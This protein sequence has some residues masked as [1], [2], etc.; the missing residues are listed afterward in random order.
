MAL[1]KQKIKE[2]VLK[3][4]KNEKDTGTPEVQI[5]LLTERIKILTKHFE[6]HKKDVLTRRNFLKLINR[7]RKLLRYLKSESIE[8]YNK[9]VKELGL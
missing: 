2:I 6:R 7:R 8:R 1:D 4:G 3:Y 9:I 5:A